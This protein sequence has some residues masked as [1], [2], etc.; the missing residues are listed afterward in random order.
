M[1][2]P[3]IFSSKNKLH[4]TNQCSK[5]NNYSHL[6]SCLLQLHFFSFSNLLTPHGIVQ[7]FFG[8]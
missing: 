3:E 4:Q 5:S 8:E 6:T 2:R 7:T 1:K